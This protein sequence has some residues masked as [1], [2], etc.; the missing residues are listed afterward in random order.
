MHDL[1]DVLLA[2][3]L[4]LVSAQHLEG[5]LPAQLHVRASGTTL[6]VPT[7]DLPP[8]P[9]VLGIKPRP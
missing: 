7:G 9:N 8:I 5:N 1:N 2:L 3:P 6:T 4:D